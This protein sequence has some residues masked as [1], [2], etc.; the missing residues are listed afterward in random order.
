MKVEKIRIVKPEVLLS[1]KFAEYEQ[2][3]LARVFMEWND[4]SY[5]ENFF[6]SNKT[7]LSGDFIAL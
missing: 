1:V 2:D 4:V 3:E 6:N 7:D 5:L